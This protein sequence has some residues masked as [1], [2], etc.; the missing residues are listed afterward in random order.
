MKFPRAALNLSDLQGK[1]VNLDFINQALAQADSK[2]VV[3][4]P[5]PAPKSKHRNQKTEIDG[6]VFDSKKEARHYL[7]LRAE[8]Q[9]GRISGLRCQVAFPLVVNGVHI[10]DYVAD[11]VY[12]RDGKQVVEDVK[13]A[14]TKK[15]REY[16]IKR[17]L[18]AALGTPI[19]EIV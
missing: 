10:C 4:D 11:F 13:S 1:G 14:H 15:L 6:R 2:T 3:A 19:T 7:D 17:N 18:M 5:P 12:V 8:Q 9:D 16:V